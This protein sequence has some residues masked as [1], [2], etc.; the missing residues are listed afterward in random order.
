MD[1]NIS[2]RKSTLFYVSLFQGERKVFV[3]V[4]R[5]KRNRWRKK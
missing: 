3:W 2:K 4:T 5:Y 1:L